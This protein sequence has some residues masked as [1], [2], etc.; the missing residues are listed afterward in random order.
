[1]RQVVCLS[2]RP[3]SASPTRT[4]PLMTRLHDAQVLYFQPPRD[5]WDNRWRE[6]GKRLRPGLILCTL[7][8]APEGDHLPGFLQRRGQERTVRFVRGVLE[9]RR[10]SEPVLWCDSPAGAELLDAFPCRGLV[11]DC[12]QE[13]DVFPETWEE[14]LAARADVVFAASPALVRRLS[15]YSPNVKLLPYGCATPMFTRSGLTRPAALA[16]VRGPILGYQG[17]LWPDLD[18]TPLLYAA[19]ARPEWTFVLVGKDA[20]SRLL[21]QLLELPNVLYLGFFEPVDLP[22]AVGSFDVC[23]SLLRR[24]DPAPDVLPPRVFEY[25]STGKP[26]VAMLRPGQVELFPD[27]VYAAKSPQEFIRLCDDALREDNPRLR[28][29]RREY[30]KAAAWTE[31]VDT[32]EQILSSIGLF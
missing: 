27:A 21:P 17:T 18:L 19:Q 32:V 2:P 30:G 7:P 12:A 5:R 14:E 8:P 1:M 26:V 24:R 20:G 29:R 13:W 3:W 31:R 22:D 11:Y 28:D 16:R 23:L 4:A 9:R 25:L 6:P 15:L 10:F